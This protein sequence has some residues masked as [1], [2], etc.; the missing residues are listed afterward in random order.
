MD[1]RNFFRLYGVGLTDAVLLG[2]AGDRILAQTGSSLNTQFEAAATEYDV[3][4]E[5]PLAMGYVNTS[6]EMPPPSA[7]SYDPDDLHGRIAYG[8]LQLV[9]NPFTEYLQGHSR[10]RLV[11]YRALQEATQERAAANVHDGAAVLAGGG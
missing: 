5:L 7:S 9:Q 10:P 2:M 1:R 4:K 6:W 11:T 3:L 8:I